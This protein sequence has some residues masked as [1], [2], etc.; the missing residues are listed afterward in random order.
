MAKEMLQEHI[1]KWHDQHNQHTRHGWV[2][3]HRQWRALKKTY[4]VTCVL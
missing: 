4:Q 1:K 2:Y 3:Y